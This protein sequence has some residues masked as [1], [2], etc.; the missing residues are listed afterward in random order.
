M[1]PAATIHVTSI[2]FVTA[3]LPIFM[4]CAG[5][6]GTATCSGFFGRGGGSVPT[7]DVAK[8]QLQQSEKTAND[9]RDEKQYCIRFVEMPRPQIFPVGAT[10]A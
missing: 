1:M 7:D 4:S 6:S 3:K 2:E 10:A 5:F 8:M 9:K